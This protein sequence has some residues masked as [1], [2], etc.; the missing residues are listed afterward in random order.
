[1]PV[2]LKG[3][4]SFFGCVVVPVEDS[5]HCERLHS[6]WIASLVRELSY[7]QVSFLSSLHVLGNIVGSSRS[8][9]SD[10]ALMGQPSDLPSCRC[11]GIRD[12]HFVDVLKMSRYPGSAVPQR[13]FWF[14]TQ[15]SILSHRRSVQAFLFQRRIYLGPHSTHKRSPSPTYQW[16]KKLRRKPWSKSLLDAS[17]CRIP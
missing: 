5:H 11:T 10:S 17:P 3:D 12:R 7:V 9:S 14:Q 2:R 4:W 13:A 15:P 16:E 6:Q 8:R 1:M